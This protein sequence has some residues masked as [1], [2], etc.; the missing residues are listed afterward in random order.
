MMALYEGDDGLQNLIAHCHGPFK[1]QLQDLLS[2]GVPV[3]IMG[4]TKFFKVVCFVVDGSCLRH[5]TAHSPAKRWH[6]PTPFSST[7][8]DFLM[9][10]KCNGKLAGVAPLTHDKAFYSRLFQRHDE[11]K[12]TCSA[13]KL[14]EWE[15]KVKQTFGVL[16][17][18]ARDSPFPIDMNQFH[19]D[20]FHAITTIARGVVIAGLVKVLVFRGA[21]ATVK[22]MFKGVRVAKGG[23]LWLRIRFRPGQDPQVI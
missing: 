23:G 21:F 5:L 14:M 7:E 17:Q 16:V 2:E 12:A 1:T 9:I 20:R 4:V 3:Q 15:E 22:K 6:I 11:V 13:K 10:R 19:L 8:R 18:Q